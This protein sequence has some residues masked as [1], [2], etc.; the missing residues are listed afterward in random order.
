MYKIKIK[1]KKQ[2]VSSHQELSLMYS[3]K[4][5][6]VR[7]ITQDGLGHAVAPEQTQMN[8]AI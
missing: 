1:S 2:W 3:A 8:L 5:N 4:R 6:E 7:T